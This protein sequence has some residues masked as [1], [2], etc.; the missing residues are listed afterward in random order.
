MSVVALSGLGP[1]PQQVGYNVI[2]DGGFDILREFWPQ[3]SH[4]L[5][6]P[7]REELELGRE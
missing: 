7:F 5:W 3:I 4:K 2:Q 1:A 6:L